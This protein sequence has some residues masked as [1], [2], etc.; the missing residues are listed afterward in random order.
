[1]ASEYF[2]N[3]ADRQA[4]R[5]FERLKR[6]SIDPPPVDDDKTTRGMTRET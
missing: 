2:L 6:R 3:R 4:T 1:M 5:A